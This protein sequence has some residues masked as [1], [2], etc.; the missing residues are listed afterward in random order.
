MYESNYT[1]TSY[2]EIVTQTGFFNIGMAANQGEG[3]LNSDH[4]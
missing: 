3:K 1:R 4:L 2:G